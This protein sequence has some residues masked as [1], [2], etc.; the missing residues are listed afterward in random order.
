MS[1]GKG[2]GVDVFDHLRQELSAVQ[3][4]DSAAASEGHQAAMSSSA[5]E[6]SAS[7]STNILPLTGPPKADLLFTLRLSFCFPH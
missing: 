4:K 2:L 3:E 1:S 6:A 5:N 7:A